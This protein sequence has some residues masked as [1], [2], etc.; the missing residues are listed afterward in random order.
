MKNIDIQKIFKNQFINDLSPGELNISSINYTSTRWDNVYRYDKRNFP[1]DVAVQ[2]QVAYINSLFSLGRRDLLLEYFPQ[3]NTCLKYLNTESTVVLEVGCG[4]GMYSFVLSKFLPEDATLILLDHS[5]E[6]LGYAKQV[7]KDRKNVVYVKA[8]AFNLPINDASVN[9]LITGG[10][11]EHFTLEQQQQLLKEFRRV[12]QH[13]VHQYPYGSLV[14]WV[15]R[16]II[17]CAN[18]LKWPFGVEVP[19][20]KGRERILFNKDYTI[21]QIDFYKRFLYRLNIRS[22]TRLSSVVEK[23]GKMLSPKWFYYDKIASR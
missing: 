1:L 23:F 2:R 16:I 6:A 5:D 11:I 13:E 20:T 18:R 8:D 14:Y 17:M 7:F 3:V 22:N 19:I 10:L 4:T 15:T 21:E 12:S 9:L